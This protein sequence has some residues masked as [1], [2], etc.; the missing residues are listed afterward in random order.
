MLTSE[1][2]RLKDLRTGSACRLLSERPE[3]LTSARQ[4]ADL[5]VKVTVQIR[6]RPFGVNMSREVKPTSIFFEKRACMPGVTR[7][8]CVLV[9]V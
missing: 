5:R 8:V 4:L 2:G 3:G 1:A 6:D 9:G 7:T